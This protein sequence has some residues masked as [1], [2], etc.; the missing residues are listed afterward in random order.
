MIEDNLL[1]PLDRIREGTR[2]Y[3]EWLEKLERGETIKL[4][5]PLVAMKRFEKGL[6]NARQQRQPTIPKKYLH[7]VRNVSDIGDKVTLTVRLTA[8]R[9]P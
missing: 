5:L 6:S 4:E 7:F 3:H 9:K 2:R 8:K 1:V